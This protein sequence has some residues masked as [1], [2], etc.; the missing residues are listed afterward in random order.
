MKILVRGLELLSP[1]GRI[2]YSTCSMNP[3]E[4]EAVVAETIR[5]SEGAVH[6]I[7]VSS[8]LP[9]LKRSPGLTTWKVCEVHLQR[10]PALKKV[11]FKK[12]RH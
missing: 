6:L 5:K 7:D 1:G 11:H 9:G 2:V 8:C 4:D 12:T 3:I 10:D